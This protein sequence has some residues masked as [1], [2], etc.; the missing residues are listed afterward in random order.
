[1]LM[2]LFSKMSLDLDLPECILM[3]RFRLTIFWQECSL[4]CPPSPAPLT[5][6][7]THTAPLHFAPDLAKS[8]WCFSTQASPTFWV[9]RCPALAPCL[10]LW[11]DSREPGTFPLRLRR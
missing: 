3:I 10:A 7:P 6:H 4:P 9:M 1:M 2:G 8:G 11:E 5:N